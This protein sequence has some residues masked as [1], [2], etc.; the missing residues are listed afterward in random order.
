MLALCF[1]KLFY[2]VSSIYLASTAISMPG[3]WSP[4]TIVAFASHCVHHVRGL[5]QSLNPVS[6]K[7]E[8]CRLL[9][10]IDAL[11]LRGWASSGWALPRFFLW[12]T[13]NADYIEIWSHYFTV[14]VPFHR[15]KL[16]NPTLRAFGFG[17]INKLLFVF[18]SIH[19]FHRRRRQIG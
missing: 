16:F 3:F 18:W 10:V 8:V 11:R 6:W 5:R 7:W 15:D 19:H 14:P 12:F 4:G 9:A 2:G 13:D 1:F 17:R